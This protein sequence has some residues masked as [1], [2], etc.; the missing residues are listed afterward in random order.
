MELIAEVLIVFVQFI[1]E[2]LIQLVGDLLAEVGWNA[3]GEFVRPSEPPRR[4]LLVIGYAIIG[5][6]FGGLSLLVFPKHF[7]GSTPLRLATLALAPIASAL[8]I[9]PLLPLLERWTKQLDIRH[10]FWN[11][12]TFSLAFALIRFAYAR[13]V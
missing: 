13:T 5:A 9:L 12:Y 11:A 6:A 7:A 2:V 10:R 1:C 8:L 4:S 3:L